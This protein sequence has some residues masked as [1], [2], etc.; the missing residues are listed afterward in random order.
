ME[1]IKE[2]RAQSTGLRKKAR[3]LLVFSLFTAISTGMPINAKAQTFAEWF[4]QKKTQKKYL[5]QQIAALQVYSGYL[6]QGYG[7]ATNGLGSISGYLRSENGMHRT[8]YSR[9]STADPLVRNNAMVKDILAWQADILKRTQEINQADGMTAPEKKYLSG[10][11]AALLK[12]CDEQLNMLQNVI[13]DN[14]VAMNDADRIALVT[15]IHSAMLANYQFA[16]GFAAQVKIVAQ[17]RQQE[18]KQVATS[19]RLNGIN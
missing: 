5:L 18:Q 14:K 13:S 3:A 7:I 4:S 16:S 9:L 19:K 12:D 15:S 17:S 10:V 1:S 2:I 8:Y 11:S 6:K